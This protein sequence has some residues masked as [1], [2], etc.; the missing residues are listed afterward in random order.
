MGDINVFTGPM[1]CGKTQKILDEAQR[2]QIAG[3]NIKVFKPALDDRFSNQQVVSR[4][5]YKLEAIG[6]N[7]I[8]EI[9][10]YDADVYVIDE[11]QFLKGN[12]DTLN[13]LAQKGKKFYISGLNLTSERKPFGKMGE[14]LCMSD[15]VQMLTAVCEVCHN[16]NAIYTYFKGENKTG[17]VLVGDE[18]YM[19]LCRKCYEKLINGEKNVNR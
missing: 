6:I 13:T 2:Q 12:I 5:G 9:N 11:F 8:E 15:N 10:D 14:L 3:K 16:D 7:N 19:P 17:D 4:K 1:K 18:C